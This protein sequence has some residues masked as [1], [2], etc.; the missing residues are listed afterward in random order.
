MKKTLFVLL[1]ALWA[2]IVAEGF[3][4]MHR[5]DST[6]GPVVWAPVPPQ[7][8][9]GL[10]RIVVVGTVECP[11]TTSTIEA[12]GMASAAFPNDTSVEIRF[13]GKAGPQDRAYRAARRVHSAPIATGLL[14]GSPEALGARTSGQT[15]I[16]APDG[17]L[18]FEGGLTQ[19][20]GADLPRHAVALYASVRNTT[21]LIHAAVYGCRIG[22]EGP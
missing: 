18:A 8:A 15:Y 3:A 5:F 2:G 19:G 13:I 1:A 12:I 14:Q 10:W 11:C 7:R 22:G 4:T 21:N 6:P 16:F 9:T 20:R 17:T